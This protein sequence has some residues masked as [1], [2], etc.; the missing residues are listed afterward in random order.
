MGVND[1]ITFR[2]GKDGLAHIGHRGTLTTLC[3][4]EAWKP[5]P[6]EGVPCEQCFA[7]AARIATEELPDPLA[8]LA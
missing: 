3:G 7:A 8:F 4:G 1:D 5:A 2:I 6:A